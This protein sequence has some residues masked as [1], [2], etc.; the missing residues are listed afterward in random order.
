MLSRFQLDEDNDTGHEATAAYFAKAPEYAYKAVYSKSRLF[1]RDLVSREVERE[2]PWLVAIQCIC[3]SPALD[4]LFVFTG[5]LGNH[6]FFMLALP[7]LHICGFG[8]FAR[9]LSFVILWSVYFSGVAKDYISAPRP[10]SPPVVQITRSPAHTFEYGFPSSHTTYVVATILYI[11]HYMLNVWGCPLHWVYTLWVVGSFIVIGRVYCG[12]HSFIDVAG[13]VV[14]GTTEA[15][16][17]ILFY[18][19]L[20]SL[21]LSTAGPLYIATVLY[22]ALSNIPRSLDL[23]PCCIDSFC[24]TSVTLGLAIGAW[25]HARMPFLWRNGVADSIAWDKSFTLAQN[26]VRSAI[27]IVLVVSWKVKSKP[28]FVALLKMLLCSHNAAKALVVHSDAQSCYNC[29][30]DSNTIVA[31]ESD[32]K[33]HSD[34]DGR[35]QAA[36]SKEVSYQL[37][38]A[39]CIKDGR[40]GTYDLMVTPENLAR[41]PIYAGIGVITYVAAPIAFYYL[42]LMPAQ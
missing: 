1:L 6:A 41:I 22:L 17:F 35:H 20:D 16:A 32:G 9:G 30:S 19:K 42:D 8:V 33:Q 18:E 40:Y 21:I 38:S 12:L 36:G 11:S 24:A 28:M 2:M 39:K 4:L 26:A 3:R 10:A 14:I 31:S 34:I 5:M 15:L 29:E 7:F 23:C 13:G 27:T 37:P 25:A